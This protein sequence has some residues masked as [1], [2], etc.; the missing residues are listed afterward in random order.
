MKFKKKNYIKL[1]NEISK[2]DYIFI[3]A[4]DCKKNFVKNNKIILRHD[5]DFDTSFAVD[6]AKIEYD[7]QIKSTYFFLM[8]DVFYDLYSEN[9]F[10]D[11]MKIKQYGHEIGLHINPHNYLNKKNKL[12]LLKDDLNYFKKFYKIKLNSISFHQP[13]VYKFKDLDIKFKFSSYNKILMKHFKYFSDSSM[14]FDY[15]GL[16]NFLATKHNIQLLIHPIWWITSKTTLQEKIKET[17]IKK[18][19]ELVNNFIKYDKIVKSKNT[20]E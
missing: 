13:S 9:T 14:K 8:R 7:N 15:K 3:L 17:F 12:K 11:L 19:S 4:K 5:I 18:K 16:K 20:Y 10:N 6:M 1:L 2:N